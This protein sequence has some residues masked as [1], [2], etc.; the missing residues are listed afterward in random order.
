MDV[1]KFCKEL[2]AAISDGTIKNAYGIEE[3]VGLIDHR[4]IGGGKSGASTEVVEA[5]IRSDS[6]KGA[7]KWLFL[8]LDV[9][10]SDEE[11]K[12]DLAYQLTEL[13]DKELKRSETEAFARNRVAKLRLFYA[14]RG[15]SAGFYDIAGGS[16]E[17]YTS[18][19]RLGSLKDH[20][21]AM[22]RVTR[23]LLEWNSLAILKNQLVRLD[24]STLEAREKV[25]PQE[26][27]ARCLEQHKKKIASHAIEQ[28][29][30]AQCIASVDD[31]GRI[32]EKNAIEF[33]GDF[34]NPLAYAWNKKLWPG[35]TPSLDCINGKT[36]GDMN[37]SNVLL[38]LMPLN[39]CVVDFAQFNEKKPLLFDNAFYQLSYLVDSLP[40]GYDL[41]EDWFDLCKALASL[42]TGIQR[43]PYLERT[44]TVGYFRVLQGAHQTIEEFS[45]SLGNSSALNEQFV[46]A[47]VA[48]GLKVNLS[49]RYIG[50]GSERRFAAYLWSVAFIDQYW[51]WKLK[52]FKATYKPIPVSSPSEIIEQ[53]EKIQVKYAE[54]GRTFRDPTTDPMSLIGPSHTLLDDPVRSPEWKKMPVLLEVDDLDSNLWFRKAF[55]I[56][57]LFDPQQKIKLPRSKNPQGEFTLS[58]YVDLS[59]SKLGIYN[60]R[61]KDFLDRELVSPY[62][63]ELCEFDD[64][65]HKHLMSFP[66]GN[67][68]QGIFEKFPRGD[69]RKPPIPLRWSSAGYLSVV[70]YS[71]RHWVLLF[72]R[73]RKPI[74]WN[75]SNGASE[76]SQERYDLYETIGREFA[77]ET[78]IIKG[79]PQKTKN[80]EQYAFVASDHPK[81]SKW[82]EPGWESRLHR[83]L[84]SDKDGLTILLKTDPNER[85]TKKIYTVTTPFDVKVS[86]EDAVPNV[87]FSVNP[88]EIGIEVIFTCGFA[89]DEEDHVIYGEVK[90]DRQ[91][92][93]RQPVALIDAEFLRSQLNEAGSFGPILAAPHSPVHTEQTCWK[94]DSAGGKRIGKIP[95]KDY[96][97]FQYD[98]ELRERESSGVPGREEECMKWLQQVK[99]ESKTPVNEMDLL[100]LTTLCPVTWKTLELG[101]KHGVIDK[102]MTKTE[103]EEKKALA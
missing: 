33:Q 81:L 8:K 47:A 5:N 23:M 54:L 97:V 50:R 43:E 32:G 67:E 84:R 19:L 68:L 61:G 101:F 49:N 40:I 41:W 14:F 10:D 82:L 58:L 93:L 48:A 95:P 83:D 18:I 11:S 12:H 77:E 62:S 38:S 2:A 29:L 28:F 57:T 71:G 9:P 21:D 92:L 99:Y 64:I 44:S 39:E 17:N 15:Q 85:I 80:V 31:L 52:D 69:P 53:R 46:L 100:Q 76:S 24:G 63:K 35:T 75:V 30:D 103:T 87:I 98:I 72:Y 4:P 55:S 22:R 7:V 86:G 56:A 37:V 59:G 36:H 42:Y 27:I 45:K 1:A 65:L 102:I 74:G 20:E 16:L 91:T 3:F 13:E 66:E 70:Y 6:M 51:K 25:H 78:V 73:D 79:D 26:L 96:R 94:C 90:D 88:Q 60:N 34:P 89:L